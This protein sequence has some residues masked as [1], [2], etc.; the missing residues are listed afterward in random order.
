MLKSYEKQYVDLAHR[1]VYVVYGLITFRMACI[2]LYI[3][4][5][6]LCLYAYGSKDIIFVMQD[7]FLFFKKNTK[8]TLKIQT[9]TTKHEEY[10]CSVCVYIEIE[11][12]LQTQV[13]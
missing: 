6:I 7:L 4:I 9:I 12:I 8:K 1:D 11:T 13:Y 5:Y 3:Y 10:Q 2:P